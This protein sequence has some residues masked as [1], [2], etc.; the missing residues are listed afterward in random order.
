VSYV[1]GPYVRLAC[2]RHL[3]D[4]RKAATR[5]GHPGGWRFD[6]AVADYVIA[7]FELVLRL[8]DTKDEHGD[9]RAFLLAPPQAFIIGSLFGWKGGDGYRR[10]RDA[11]IEI[12][13]G[14]GKT[15]LLAG[16]GLYGL[17]EDEELAAEIYATATDRNQARIMF[18]DAERIVAASPDLADRVKKTVNNLADPETMSFFRPFSKDQ[19]LKSGWRPHMGLIDELHEHPSGE[20]VMKIR[21]GAKGRKQ[22]LFPEI[23]NSGYDRTSICW[24]HREHSIR[25]LEGTVQDDRW[26][27]YVCALDDGDDPLT[28]R[29]CHPKANPLL[30]VCIGQDYLDRQ[31]DVAKNIPP[32]LNTVLRL[33]FCIWTQA[34]SRVID[35]PKWHGCVQTVLDAELVG[36]PCYA[37]LDLGQSDDFC[38]FVLV[39]FLP[40][41]RVAVRARFWVPRVALE[42]RPHRPYAEWERAGVLDVTE[43]DITDYDVVEADVMAACLEAGAIEC[44]YDKRFAQHMALHLEAAGV[45]MTDMPQGFALNEALR[46]IIDLVIAGDLAHDGNPILGWMAANLVVRHGRNGEIRPDKEKATEKIDGMV[47]LAMAVARGIVTPADHTSKYEREGLVT[48]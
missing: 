4:R 46:K 5:G 19:G 40:D 31:V 15:P 1:A 26:F 14:N 13:K 37:A 6:Q 23:T 41:G 12:G 36:A 10:F 9:P 24:Q 43:G 30:G 11:Y 39:W 2:R 16:I 27:P 25:V 42:R 35:M 21:A 32:E 8:P 3:E 28:D 47:A 33:N 18:Q 44:A 22:P 48:V 34:H 29:A 38:A 45:T 17:T 7:F 20:I